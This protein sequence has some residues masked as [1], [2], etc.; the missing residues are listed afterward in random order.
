M[1]KKIL[2]TGDRPTGALH[3]GHYAGSLLNRLKMQSEFETFLMVADAQAI[4]DNY[5]NIDK[6]RE[7]IFEVVA[8]YLAVGIDPSQVNIF[9]QS[10]IP[11]LPELTQYLLNL[12]SINRIGHN[13][14]VKA[15]CRQKGFEESVPAGF[16][17]YPIFQVA[18][19]IAFDADVVPVGRD[20]APMLELTRDVVGKFNTQYQSNVLVE[21][22]AV[23]PD[24]TI[25][26]PGIDGNKMSKSLGN[27]IYLKDTR[28]E[29]SKKIKKMK[30]DSSRT[31]INDPG[32]P[33][34]AIAFS[35]LDIFDPDVEG[36]EKLK[37]QYKQ[38][39]LGD[40]I[41]KERTLE[42]LDN[43]IAPIR[44]KREAIISDKA[45]IEKVLSEGTKAAREK[46]GQTL[47]RCKKAMGINYEFLDLINI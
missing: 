20:Q 4:T 28:A 12:V 2:L 26:L 24:M 32:D 31:S 18:D 19:I 39:G 38:G 17:L 16:Y 30:S 42:V 10:M 23:F 15:E 47:A 14:T 1:K 3:I 6:V 11:E 27:A 34:K 45:M 44:E 35:Y 9:I 29:I 25:N 43:F 36:V 46:A 5:D 41:V 7:N 33:A 37:H 40:G 22:E 21:P 8:D 13:P